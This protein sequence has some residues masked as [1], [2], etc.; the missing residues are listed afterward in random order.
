[1]QSECL[2]QITSVYRFFSA[3][4]RTVLCKSAAHVKNH[5][6]IYGFREF[7]KFVIFV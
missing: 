6:K 5:A 3:I 4:F 7:H 2:E 1:V